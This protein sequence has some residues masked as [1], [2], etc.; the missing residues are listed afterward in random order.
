MRFLSFV[1]VACFA[2]SDLLAVPV[3]AAPANVD[4]SYFNNLS[5]RLVGPFRGGRALAVT[6]VP[7]EPDHF[8]FGAVDGG[9]WEST[10]AGRTWNPI[11]D[12]QN[13]GSI[14]AIAVAPSAPK[15]L[16]V[17]SGEA[18]MRSDIAYGN[19][20]YKTTDGGKTWTHIGLENTYQIG[21]VVVDP[22]DANTVYVAALGHPY[23]A[24]PER[25]VFKTTDGGA[26][27][28]KVLSKDNDTG[29]ISLAMDPKHPEVVYAS[30]WQT[31][32][33]P[34]NVY[35]PSN[36]PGSGLYKSTDAGKTWTQLTTGL[37][38]KPGR[39]GIAVAPSQPSRVYAQI[40]TPDAID[41]GGVY[42]SDDGG[43]TWAHMAGGKEQIRIW[44]R[45]WYFSGITVDPKNP[46]VVYVMDTATYRSDN[47]G[48]TFNAIKGSP[49]GDDYHTLWIE[50]DDSSRMV[51]G[52]DQGVV[53]SVDRG[54]TW[55]SW[56]N[57]PT[58]QLY[59][60][61]TDNRY[62]Y[63]A[64]GAQQDSGAI[65][66]PSMTIHENIT[67]LDWRPIDVGYENG[68]IAADPQRPGYLFGTGGS[69]S[70]EDI[71]TGWEQNVDPTTAYPGELYR[72]TWTMPVVISQ[73]DRTLYESRQ[74][75]FRS[76][77]RGH[78][79]TIISPDLTRNDP[80][81]NQL[82]NL[83]A[84]TNADNYGLPRRGV[85]YAI[86]P[87]PL[88]AGTLWAGTDDGYVW[89]TTDG[90]AHWSNVTPKHLTPWSKVGIIDASHLDRNTAYIAVDRHRLDDYTPY[91]YKTTDGGATWTPIKNG[92]PDGSF[93]NVVRAD[94]Q[95]RGL[96][97]AGTEKGV[98]VSFDDGA[99]WQSLQRNLPVTSIRDIDVHGNDLVIGTHGRSIWIMDDIAPLRE[100][101]RGV[102]S[103]S[104]YLFSPVTTIRFRRAGGVGGGVADEGTPIQKDE[105]M[106]PNPPLGAY[107]DYYL[108]SAS[109]TPVSIAIVGPGGRVLRQYS[110]ADKPD[111]VDPATQDIA[112]AWIPAP[113]T[114]ATD[115]GA[116]RFVWD[117]T[118]RHDGG[119]LGPPGKYEVR[120]TANGTTIT[121]SFQLVRDPRINVSDKE[122]IAQFTAANQIED[123]LLRIDAAAKHAKALLA[124]PSIS[125]ANKQI[126]RTQV[127]GESSSDNP[128]NSVPTATQFDTL[129]ALRS[130]FEQLEAAIESVDAL[131]THD[132]AL[133]Y[134]KLQHMLVNTIVKI[135]T[136]A[137]PTK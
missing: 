59:H 79:W 39:I 96:L 122:L 105:P 56:L 27:W 42:R 132:Q 76:T 1:L 14:G 99:N 128:D 73:A 112:P 32:R 72:Q 36:G 25:G 53:V 88:A 44:E 130:S 95:V 82:P 103:G 47:G 116:H 54:I 77:D 57:Q 86:A 106:A 134:L 40:D 94:P 24:N 41:Q 131:P 5:W 119:P 70:Y 98:Y 108:P 123:T 93:V 118:T 107:I 11:F 55:S 17:G 84:A 62:P 75:I 90:G 20:V 91:I 52:S 121:R 22:R 87:S 110:S 4:P 45:G 26:T 113:V 15:T 92:I 66:V 65:A 80:S 69:S 51:L 12:G 23:A 104:T 127:L 43:A 37:P 38:A 46:D 18:D 136:I 71:A 124:D 68:Y 8:Y 83:D 111:A 100:I 137:G 10:N 125:E 48:K 49:G 74:Q 115:A 126:L 9:I 60:V 114:V 120:L 109:S 97:Y 6:G 101:A 58:A 30:L 2:L 3:Q 31:R 117:F 63:W 34:W 7:G 135:A 78:T 28:T 35:P 129:R 50:P 33:P 21:A 102:T 133:G 16:Y 13:V 85:V 64:Y 89:R 61:T 67:S 81:E 29:A 19:G